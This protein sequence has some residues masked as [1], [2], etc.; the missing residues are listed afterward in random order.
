VDR[1][2][3][4]NR[5][6]GAPLVSTSMNA[7]CASS[8]SLSHRSHLQH[9]QHAGLQQ[10]QCRAEG[11]ERG[12]GSED[13]MRRDRQPGCKSKGSADVYLGSEQ[14]S[15]QWRCALG[16]KDGAVREGAAPVPG[17][18]CCGSRRAAGRWPGRR[19]SAS[20]CRSACSAAAWPAPA[21]EDCDAR[22][23]G[24]IHDESRK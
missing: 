3:C 4:G 18:R 19:S 15:E 23:R 7:L 9:V 5:C 20:P 2:R 24:T 14:E 10:G 17:S 22:I 6:I 12:R 8:P 1:I 11:R 16:D 21:Q 13:E